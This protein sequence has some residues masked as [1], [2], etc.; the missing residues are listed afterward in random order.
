MKLEFSETTS[1]T[2]RS[3]PGNGLGYPNHKDRHCRVS[4]RGPKISP[5]RLAI[6]LDIVL[7]DTPASLLAA[8]LPPAFRTMESNTAGPRTR[9]CS[10]RRGGIGGIGGTGSDNRVDIRRPCNTS[11]RVW[12]T[13]AVSHSRHNPTRPRPVSTGG[14]CP[15]DSLN[16]SPSEEDP[17]KG[18][19]GRSSG[20]LPKEKPL[21]SS[22]FTSGSGSKMC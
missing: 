22:T 21:R 7:H 10:S 12:S 11:E 5:G 19:K 20:N 1:S 17:Q 2:T 14:L 9:K 6:H 13:S 18:R 3:R 4:L 8:I 15:S 16:D